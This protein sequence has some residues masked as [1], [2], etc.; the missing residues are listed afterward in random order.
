MEGNLLTNISKE[1]LECCSDCDV[2]LHQEQNNLVVLILC[3][4]TK[5]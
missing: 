3:Q 1:V 5:L 4:M 2:V